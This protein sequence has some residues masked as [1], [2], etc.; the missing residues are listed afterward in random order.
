M[1][2]HAGMLR[3]PVQPAHGWEAGEEEIL[4]KV[5]ETAAT[6]IGPRIK[7]ASATRTSSHGLASLA[8]LSSLCP[9]RAHSQNLLVNSG[10]DR[11]LSGWTVRIV[12]GSSS[13]ASPRPSAEL[14][15]QRTRPGAR[16]P[17]ARACTGERIRRL[18]AR[19]RRSASVFQS[20][21]RDTVVAFGALL[22]TTR[23]ELTQHDADDGWHFFASRDVLRGETLAASA[24]ALSVEPTVGSNSGGVWVP[25]SERPLVVPA[26]AQS[27]VL[28]GER[29]GRFG[30]GPTAA[31]TSTS[32]P[33]TPS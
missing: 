9:F 18:P 16:I 3:R 7:C 25:A 20:L 30:R 32:S 17:A 1:V 15:R 24:P 23:A 19:R 13:A 2:T 22:L 10:F 4:R 28:R 33:T 6:S 14:D 27:V 29:G 21:P 12:D 26:A 31:V 5:V 11:D 8:S